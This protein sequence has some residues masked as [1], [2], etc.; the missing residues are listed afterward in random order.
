MGVDKDI[1][2]DMDTAA[3]ANKKGRRSVGRPA[4]A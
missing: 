2:T 3:P 4:F 1:D